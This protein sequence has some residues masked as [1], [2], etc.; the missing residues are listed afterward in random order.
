M[1][2]KSEG[3]RLYDRGARIVFTG[4]AH[5]VLYRAEAGK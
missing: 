5:L 3:F 1:T 2:I 4:K